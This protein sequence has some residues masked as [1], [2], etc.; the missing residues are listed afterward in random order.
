MEKILTEIKDVFILKPNVFHDD[1]G[2]FLET[3]SSKKYREFGINYDF[4]QDNHS[5][6]SY[7]VLRGLHYQLLNPQ[8]KLVRVIHGSVFD[9]AVDIRKGSPTFGKYVSVDLSDENK[10]QFWVPP[11]FAHGFVVTSE[12]AELEYKVTDYYSPN[13]EGAIIWNDPDLNISWPIKSPQ[14]SKKDLEAS[15]LSEIDSLNLPNYA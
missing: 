3:Y 15:R 2:F 1:R 11:G 10:L 13:D 7:G 9:I 6:S 12:V 5:R 4:V 8:G 14:L